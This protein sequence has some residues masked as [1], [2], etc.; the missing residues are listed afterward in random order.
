MLTEPLAGLP[1]EGVAL[2]AAHFGEAPVHVPGPAHLFE[3]GGVKILMRTSRDSTFPTTA[4]DSDL[5][6]L[7]IERRG[8]HFIL[9]VNPSD[10]YLVPI[11]V[12]ANAYREA[13]AYWLANGAQTGGS[14]VTPAIHLDATGRFNDYAERWRRY[15]IT[16]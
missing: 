5:T 3:A 7:D 15:R 9:F 6:E 4:T 13:H 14:N 11:K 16:A 8:A 1:A 2:L 12:A 10:R